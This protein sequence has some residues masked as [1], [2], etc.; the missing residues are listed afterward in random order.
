[1]GADIASVD[2]RRGAI[3]FLPSMFGAGPMDEMRMR[4]IEEE[5]ALLAEFLQAQAAAVQELIDHAKQARARAQSAV[6]GSRRVRAKIA[7]RQA[8]RQ[9]SRRRQRSR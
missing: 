5:A 1:M 2:H 4:A 9:P 7:A 8:G 3:W 6:D